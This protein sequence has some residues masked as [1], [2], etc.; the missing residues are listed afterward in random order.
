MRLPLSYTWFLWLASLV[1]WSCAVGQAQISP[2]PLSRAH[3]GLE[4]LTKCASCHAFGTAKR[5]F[6]C[7]ECHVEI[8]K[9]VEAKTGFHA[10][11]YKRQP[12]RSIARV[13]TRSTR[14]RRRR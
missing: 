4:G 3:Q 13:A 14:A 5:S 12:G 11:A 9:R 10:R 1:V 7:L 2:G 6:K 8:N